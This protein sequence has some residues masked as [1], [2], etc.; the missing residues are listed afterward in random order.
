MCSLISYAIYILLVLVIIGFLM[1][2]KKKVKENQLMAKE[3]YA[4][5]W[6]NQEQMIKLL[7]EIRDALKK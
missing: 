3:M 1:L 7:T 6:A 4:K 5:S 2:L